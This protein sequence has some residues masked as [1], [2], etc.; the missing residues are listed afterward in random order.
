MPDALL[1][2]SPRTRCRRWLPTG[3]HEQFRGLGLWTYLQAR[4]RPAVIPGPRWKI[5]NNACLGE[6]R[7][8]YGPACARSMVAEWTG[9]TRNCTPEPLFQIGSA[10]G[11]VTSHDFWAVDIRRNMTLAV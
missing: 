6:P 4:R 10:L 5:P 3:H 1:A 7:R 8:T 11:S 9:E 2:M